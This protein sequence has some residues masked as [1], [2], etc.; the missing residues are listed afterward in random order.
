MRTPAFLT[1]MTFLK[2]NSILGQIIV[3]GQ[4]VIAGLLEKRALQNCTNL[5]LLTCQLE[6]KFIPSYILKGQNSS[7]FFPPSTHASQKYWLRPLRSLPR[8]RN[9]C[10]GLSGRRSHARADYAHSHVRRRR[11]TSVNVGQTGRKQIIEEKC[12]IDI[13]NV[14]KAKKAVSRCSGYVQYIIC[15]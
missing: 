12:H 5:I 10:A 1:R 9:T 7:G 2:K 14:K 8:M 6:R 3:Q 11:Q 13:V 15:F 4:Y